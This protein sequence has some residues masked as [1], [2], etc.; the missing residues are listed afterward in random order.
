V[1]I[2][3]DDLGV[4]ALHGAVVHHAAVGSGVEECREA[5]GPTAIDGFVVVVERPDA[6]ARGV[7]HVAPSNAEREPLVLH[8]S[9]DFYRRRGTTPHTASLDDSYVEATGDPDP[10]EVVELQFSLDDVGTAMEHLTDLEREVIR[11]R[12]AADLSI[13]DTAARLS[14]SENNVKQL[15]HKALHKLRGV[16]GD[17]NAGTR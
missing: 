12:Y 2:M 1:S 6:E 15:T 16:L 5:R 4:G 10:A 14:K 11:L 17:R 7:E 3:E 9:N 8:V 13:A